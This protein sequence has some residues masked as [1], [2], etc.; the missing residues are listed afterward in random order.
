MFL[1][2][3]VPTR[4]ILEETNLEPVV[5]I[6]KKVFRPKF[7]QQNLIRLSILTAAGPSLG[8]IVRN[9]GRQ[10]YSAIVVEQL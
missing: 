5:R 4:V 2:K 3:E 1:V 6:F 8:K 7:I 9:K 10:D